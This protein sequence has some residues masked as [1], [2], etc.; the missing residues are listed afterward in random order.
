MSVKTVKDELLSYLMTQVSGNRFESFAK[1]LFSFVFKESFIPLGGIHDGGA[2]GALS[3]YI[4]EV[5]GKTNT[6]IQ[7]T[8]T[9]E[10]KVKTKIDNTI[11][12]LLDSGRTPRQLIYTTSIALPKFDVIAQDVFEKHGVMV[13]F[14]DFDR[15]KS[16][17]NTDESC[18]QLFYVF[19]ASEITT[20]AN[21]AKSKLTAVSEYA[22]DP[23]V[24]VY[25]N[26]ELKNKNIKN[27]L[28]EQVLDALI[29]W[30]LRDTDPDAGTL[31]SRLDIQNS[32]SNLF[33]QAKS[34]LLPNLNSRLEALS[35][36]SAG[37]IERLRYYKQKDSFSLPFEMRT[38][39][40]IEASAAISRQEEF[41]KSIDERLKNEENEEKEGKF[42]K[43]CNALVFQTVHRYFIDQGL[44]LAA[45]LEGKLENI[46][47]SDQVVEDIMARVLSEIE[48]GKSLPPNLFGTCLNILRGIFYHPSSEEREYMGYLS[49]TSCLLVTMQSA[50]KLLEYFNKM[51]GNFKLLIG[52]DLIVKAIS[53][54]YIAEEDKQVTRI[55][56][57]CKQLG[58]ELIL[59][60]PVLDEVF[61]H[62]H[63]TDLEFRNHYA[64]QEKYLHKDMVVDSDRIMIR[65]YFHSKKYASG[66]KTW[67][68]FIEQVVTHSS[69]R[70][71]SEA[72]R[73]D[74]K[75]FLLQKFS[76][77]FISEEDLEASV[78]QNKVQQLADK[79]D[80]ARQDKHENLSYNDALMAHATY[81]Q[82]RKNNESGIY[83]GFGFRTWW[84]TKETRVLHFSKS[85][86]ESEGG[87]PYIMRPEFILNFVSLAANADNVRKS[88][89]DLLPTTAGLQLGRH[90]SSA[91]M[92]DLMGDAK[93][94]ADRP[95]ERISIM[96]NERAN[97]L[98]YD[99][100]KK[101][102]DNI[103]EYTENK[104]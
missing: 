95:A 19:F 6:F 20:L 13:H 11:K 100:F 27:H 75:G 69:L 61:T 78:N 33:P 64:E 30:S 15:I 48:H 76:M 3:S 73:Q 87:V 60:E 21:S 62:L 67:I 43:T 38:N 22:T 102:Y 7:I 91:T 97:R 68:Q 89:S 84:L 28:N 24:Y 46:C 23:T 81:A 88:F 55:L 83:D 71:R 85:L 35:K 14:R 31:I 39:L 10:E 51:G 58:S 94:W 54:R 36:K 104:L 65:A 66:P 18:N 63:A 77:R 12:A 101:Y 103:D 53:E 2:D 29:Y 40:A 34:V 57:V 96:I 70:A 45:F 82:R 79:L 72:A 42:N 92:H 26:Y 17:I 16:Y 5:S 52:T 25:L 86:V 32:I 93:E 56:D 49:K 59:S 4:Q 50:P 8:T 47:I 9:A 98:K 80:E 74:L 1:Q 99:Q 41:K 90:L 37:D 44:L